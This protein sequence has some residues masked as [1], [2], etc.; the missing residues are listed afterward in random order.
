M[1]LADNWR[2]LWRAWSM[3]ALALGA[4]LPELLDALAANVDGVPVV[5]DGY[6][7]GIRLAAILAAMMLRVVK[8]PAVSGPAKP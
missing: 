6:K 3:W 2:R 1:K 5:N 4:A 7:S 8:Q